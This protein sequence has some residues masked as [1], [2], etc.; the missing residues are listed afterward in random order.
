VSHDPS[1]KKFLA[2]LLGLFAASS[3]VPKM[4]AKS[5]PTSAPAIS[6]ETKP[7]FQLRSVP[8]TVARRADSL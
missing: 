7:E 1:R 3:I 4:F 5:L 2:R 8:R 6:A